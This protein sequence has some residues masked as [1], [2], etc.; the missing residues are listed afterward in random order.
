V[1]PL[2]RH[3]SAK[4]SAVVAD[5]DGTLLTDDKILTPGTQAAVDMLHAQGIIF[6][7]ISSRPPRGMRALL[8]PL[9]I[10]TPLCGF[11]GGSITTPDLA[12]ITEHLLPPQIARRAIDLLDSQS[13]QAWVFRGQDWLLRDPSA[14]Y[15]GFEERT[16]GFPPTIVESFEH[17]MD[18]VAKIVGVS[19]DFERLTQCEDIMREAL[20][21]QASVVRSQRY[22]LDVTHLAANKGTALA[23]LAGLL[24]VPLAEIAVVGDGANDVAMFECAGLAIAMGNA[25]PEVQR[26]ADLVT[27]GN[28]NDGFAVA[29]ERFILGGD[30]SSVPG[31]IT[32]IADQVP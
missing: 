17:V 19:G 26:A 13:V 3:P 28:Q 25:A 22:Y 21:G 1:T 6:S 27:D 24:A 16:V 5:V 4:I 11:N 18:G 9:G 7:I 32:R 14:P 23:Q 10:T 20:S 30:R 29:A 12:V 15:V 31:A 2:S 8:K